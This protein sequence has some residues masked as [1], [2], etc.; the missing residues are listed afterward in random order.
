VC[1]I[2]GFWHLAGPRPGAHRAIAAMTRTLRHRGPD[3]EGYLLVESR[4]GRCRALRGSETVPEVALPDIEAAAVAEPD[5]ALGFRRLS[6]I[7]RSPAGHQPMANARGSLWI[8]YNGE[9]YNYLELRSELQAKGQEFRTSSDT[10]V[11]L[12]AYE[13]WGEACVE[14]FNGMWAFALWDARRR[15][16]FCSRDRFGVKPLYYCWDGRSFAFGSE[17]K[18][19]L[20]LDATRRSVDHAAAYDFLAYGRV[21]H[22]EGTFFAGIHRLQ[23]GHS[24]TVAAEGGLAASRYYGFPR[25]AGAQVEGEGRMEARAEEL[26]GLLTDAV[27]LRL[28][29]DVPV[30]SCLSGGLDSS[31]IVCL[32]NRLLRAHGAGRPAGAQQTFT[33]AF[34]DPRHD[35]RD[36]CRRVVEATGVEPRYV[37]PDGRELWKELERLLWHQ[38]EPFGSTSIYAQWNVM[39]LVRQHGVTVVLD[40]QGSDELF[41]GYH[42]YYGAYL[43]TLLRRGR[44]RRFAA[45]LLAARRVV[46][47]TAAQTALRARSAVAWA[48]PWAG[49]AVRAVRG[50]APA[51]A[52]LLRRDFRGV[53]DRAGS[54]GRPTS[55]EEQLWQDVSISSLPQLLRYEDRNSMAFSVEARVP[56][57]DVRVAEFAARAPI[58]LKIRDGWTKAVLREA[59]R[60][61]VPDEV[62]WRRD[63]KGFPTPEQ[64]WWRLNA[65]PIRELFAAPRSAG[66]VDAE[67]V[68]RSLPALMA[69]PAG[70]FLLWRLVCLE[71]WM[72]VWMPGGGV[73]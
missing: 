38:E 66:I 6:I 46:G 69:A 42:P 20:S 62:R 39:R 26:L 45:E 33:S 53:R 37:F 23:P 72:Q 4:A 48:L 10:E 2:A 63:K 8:V 28:R 16:L 44:A 24:L 14:R 34:D 52:P 3:D 36:F 27:R 51:V 50:S 59:V 70:D 32:M 9:V 22:G 49:D 5:L 57:L 60:G 58:T 64:E 12:A 11:I 1:G 21:D 13:A 47:W 19:L 40:G 18:A 54:P 29:A 65:G 73:G 68:R 30:G 71:K 43:G 61:I 17:I 31:A 67:A 35:E 56:F 25:P 7:D 55:L 15:R 41:A